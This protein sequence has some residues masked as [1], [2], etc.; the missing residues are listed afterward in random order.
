MLYKL[1]IIIVIIVSASFAYNQEYYGCRK[2]G[3]FLIFEAANTTNTTFELTD[4]TLDF[5]WN[6][7]AK[8]ISFTY[9]EV[10]MSGVS[11]DFKFF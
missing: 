8:N 10:F 2:P 9:I 7:M 11:K 1:I 5:Y 3:D 4:H 6:G